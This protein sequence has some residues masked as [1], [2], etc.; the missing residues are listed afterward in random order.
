MRNIR[1]AAQFILGNS[2]PFLFPYVWTFARN[3][4][5]EMEKE[6]LKQAVCP[7]GNRLAF[8]RETTEESGWLLLH[9]YDAALSAMENAQSQISWRDYSGKAS[10][11]SKAINILHELTQALENRDDP[12]A[13][14][15]D[16]LYLTCT[17]KLVRASADMDI[18][19]VESARVIIGKLRAA[20][21]QALPSMPKR[22]QKAR[23]LTFARKNEAVAS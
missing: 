19:P 10:S 21:A 23:I 3:D 18:K 13:H 6:N 12:L 1:K 5:K 8:K 11:I 16:R 9:M 20:V 14:N 2:P 22:G 15:L 4:K 17:V 7:M